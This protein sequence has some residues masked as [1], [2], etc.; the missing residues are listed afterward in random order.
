MGVTGSWGPVAVAGLGDS[1]FSCTVGVRG[2]WGH[3]RMWTRRC[4]R[5]VSASGLGGDS[6][7]WRGMRCMWADIRGW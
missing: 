3:E 6:R 7:R 5:T 1:S 2:E 4:A